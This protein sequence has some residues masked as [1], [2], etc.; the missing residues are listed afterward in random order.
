MYVCVL[1]TCDPMVLETPLKVSYTFNPKN[2]LIKVFCGF[3]F[4]N[5]SWLAAI[6]F[7]TEFWVDHRD[8]KTTT[9]VKKEIRKI[10]LKRIAA[11]FFKGFATGGNI[12][13]PLYIE[14]Q[15]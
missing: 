6:K 9:D 2:H 11:L 5:F 8:V 10:I 15:R 7:A 1:S 4:A 3:F 13:R 14:L 12:Y